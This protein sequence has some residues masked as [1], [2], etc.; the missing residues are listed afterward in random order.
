MKYIVLRVQ[1]PGDNMA[2]EFPFVFAEHCIHSFVAAQMTA[3][4]KMQYPKHTLV[5]CVGAGMFSSMTFADA[6][7]NGKSDSLGGLPSRGEVD[8]RLLMMNDYGAMH[9]DV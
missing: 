5:E 4:L 3:M 2:M 9:V 6:E 8:K 7:P 1:K